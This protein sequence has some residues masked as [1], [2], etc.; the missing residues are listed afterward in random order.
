M[1]IDVKDI[2]DFYEIRIKSHVDSVNYFAELLG[3]HFPEHDNDKTV[4]PIRTGYA[5]IFYDAYHKNFHP[6]QQ[7]DDLCQDAKKTHHKHATHHIEFYKDVSEIP[8]ICVYEMVSDWASAS[9]EQQH[10]IHADDAAPL[11][12]WFENKM[13]ALPWTQHQKEIINNSFKIIGEKTDVNA[14][15]KIW[16]PVLELADL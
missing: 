3:Y 9:F 7:H 11:E 1:N 12:K 14:V 2:F 5:Y 16:A 13:S 6:T 8:D 4:E 15:K 10:I